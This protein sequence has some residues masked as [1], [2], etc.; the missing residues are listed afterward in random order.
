MIQNQNKLKWINIF[1]QN[2]NLKINNKKKQ[3]LF[4]RM[5]VMQIKVLN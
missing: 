5:V 4:N 1:N 3:V 2:N